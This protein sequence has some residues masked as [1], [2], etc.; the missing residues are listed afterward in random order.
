MFKSDTLRTIFSPRMLVAFA[1]GFSSGMPLLLTGSV[2]QAWMKEEGVDLGTIGLFALVGLPY[3]LKFLWA[4]VLDRY[5]LPLL[6][7]R[8]GWLLVMQVALMLAIIGL[9]LTQPATNAWLV[10]LIA[11]LVTFFSASQDIVVDAYRR[12]DLTDRELGLGSSLYVSGYRVG[13]LVT[14]GGGLILADWLPFE[15]VYLLFGLTMLLG[16]VTTLWAPE[17]PAVH[18]TPG[19]LREAVVQPFLEYFA[20]PDAFWFLAFILLYKI[21]DVM[22]TAISTPFYLELGFSKGEIGAVVKLFGFWATVGGGILGGV[23]MLRTGIYRALWYFGF[24]Q[25]VTILGFA[26]LAMIG[27]SLPALA[28]VI[29][30]ENLTGGMGT[31]AYVAFMASL[32]DKRFTATQYALLTSLMGIPRVLASAPTGYLAEWLGWVGFF[33]FCTLAAVPGML[34]LFHFKAWG[35][36]ATNGGWAVGDGLKA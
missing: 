31:T 13:L 19:S 22:A 34:I 36:A 21:G 4:P 32:T 15:T 8:R 5:T 33:L 1:M 20:R 16:I 17:P 12:E 9:G 7:R 27:Y 18:G 11:L 23:I 29:A 24:L 10:A 14:G 25:M 6:G 28:A 35:S 30:A 2:L 26:A 3:T